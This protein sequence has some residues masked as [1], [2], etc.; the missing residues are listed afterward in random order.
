MKTATVTILLL[1]LGLATAAQADETA[2]YLWVDQ[3]GIPH[4]TDRPPDDVNARRTLIQARRT[5]PSAVQ[6][7]VERD[8]DLRQA[9]RTRRQDAE[10]AEAEEAATRA[11]TLQQRQ[12]N[13]EQARKKLQT[14]ETSRRLYRPLPNGERE[15]LTDEELDKARADARAQVR[16]WC[17]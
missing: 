13:C 5:D 3:N 14:Y 9:R 10:E 8:R 7:R 1:A 17:D 4:Y 2:V 11:E 16:E 15:Y 12:R 6:A